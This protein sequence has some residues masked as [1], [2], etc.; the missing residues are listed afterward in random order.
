M[1]ANLVLGLFLA[2]WLWMLFDLATHPVAAGPNA[3]GPGFRWLSALTGITT[4]LTAIFVMRRAPGNLVG[5]LLLLWGVGATGWS[6]RSEWVN[7]QVGTLASTAF[8]II[9]FCIS[10]PAAILLLLLFPDGK[11]YPSRLA[12]WLPLLTG[13]M[14]A[15]GMFYLFGYYA[16]D[17]PGN[18]PNLLYVP[19]LRGAGLMIYLVAYLGVMI[20]ALVTLFLRYRSGD[21]RLRLQI[22]WLGWLLGVGILLGVIPFERLFGT[23]VAYWLLLITYIFWQSF[24]ALGIGIAVLRHNLWG[25]DIVI[26]KTLVYAALTALLALFYFGSVVLLQRLF[27]ALTGVEQSPLAVVISTLAIAALFTP[28]RRRVQDGIDRRFYRK[29]YD[30]QRVLAAFAVTARDETDLDALTGELARVVQETLQP[31]RV[32]VWL[33]QQRV[34]LRAGDPAPEGAHRKEGA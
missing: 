25:V 9:F 26:R 13:L 20:V 12:R 10:C 15:A 8:G 31:E 6:L 14:V 30:A 4:V 33:S 19:S 29:K 34:Q 21:E 24:L 2:Y 27:G 18:I 7:V 28:L 5:P 17:S 3:G 16:P 23:Q 11:P 32:G 22:R 1:L